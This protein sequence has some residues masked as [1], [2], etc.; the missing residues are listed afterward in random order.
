MKC[1]HRSPAHVQDVCSHQRGLASIAG[2]AGPIHDGC[3]QVG[4]GRGVLQ[5]DARVLENLTAPLSALLD[6]ASTT[7]QGMQRVPATIHAATAMT[8]LAR[9]CIGISQ[10]S[11][12]STQV[13]GATQAKK[14]APEMVARV[15][16]GLLMGLLGYAEDLVFAEAPV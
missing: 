1:T 8:T 16:N 4:H 5:N 6:E 12:R 2:G 13:T 7:R 9:K 11:E 3:Q 10:A 14:Y 15:R